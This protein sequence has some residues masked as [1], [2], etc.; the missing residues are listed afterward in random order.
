MFSYFKVANQLKIY[1]ELILVRTTTSRF[2]FLPL[3]IYLWL[4]LAGH[5]DMRLAIKRTVKLITKDTDR[6]QDAKKNLR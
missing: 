1:T 6:A 3:H 2:A 4:Q 5:S